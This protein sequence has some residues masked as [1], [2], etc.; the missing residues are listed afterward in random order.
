MIGSLLNGPESFECELG[1]WAPKWR[2]RKVNFIERVRS[3]ASSDRFN[4]LVIAM[5]LLSAVL[6]GLETD[7]QIM[8]KYGS[9]L[10]SLDQFVISFFIFE[11]SLKILSFGR[12]P[13]LYFKDPWNVIDLFIV[14]GCL[15]PTGSNAMAI[16]RLVRVLRVLRLITALPKLQTIVSALLKSIPSMSY[17]VVI[18]G[19]HFYM[20]GV[21]GTFLFAENDPVHFGG[22]GS[23]FLTLFQTLTLEGWAD[24]MRIQIYGCA[25]FGYEN[26]P[27][28]CTNSVA[29]PISAVL[30]FITFIV[31]GT[32]II[33]N[34]LIG[35]VVNGMAESQEEMEGGAGVSDAALKSLSNEIR[36]L[37][38][39][40]AGFRKL[41]GPAKE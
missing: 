19:I 35:V 32:M 33:L 22:L 6:L 20:F 5:I 38:E 37:R 3:I 18:L 1:L 7:A 26:F 11:I 14:I 27:G 31:M 10:K 13:L 41:S 24:L 30:Y 23:T 29:Q 40:M 16:F 39:E 25:E 8:Q 2:M 9:Q 36:V 4:K 15:I 17:V 34:L 28:Q 12:R 21:L